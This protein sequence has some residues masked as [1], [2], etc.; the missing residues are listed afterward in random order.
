LRPLHRLKVEVEARPLA[1]TDPTA[2]RLERAAG[3]E[4]DQA[5]FHQPGGESKD[6]FYSDGRTLERS[7]SPWCTRSIVHRNRN[8]ANSV[9]IMIAAT[10]AE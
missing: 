8:G 4:R 3:N 10:I 5:H 2:G 1:E 9:A 6:P 7:T